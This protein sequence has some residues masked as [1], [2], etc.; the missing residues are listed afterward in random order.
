MRTHYLYRFLIL[1]VVSCLFEAQA[2][3]PAIAGRKESRA[4]FVLDQDTASLRQA[5]NNLDGKRSFA[6]ED[7]AE[8]FGAIQ[9][10]ELSSIATTESPDLQQPD[11]PDQP[12][13]FEEFKKTLQ[14]TTQYE[15]DD[16]TPA[17]LPAT[18]FTPVNYYVVEEDILLNE[19]ELL[20]FHQQ[21]QELTRLAK[22]GSSDRSAFP[23]SFTSADPTTSSHIQTPLRAATEQNKIVR[24][25]PGSTLRYSIAKWTFGG[26]TEKYN[27][28]K[29]NM[30]AAC[31]AWEE[32][33]NIKFEH[34]S[35]L[36][37]AARGTVFPV[38]ANGRRQ[39]LF[40]VV[41]QDI[42]D[43]I[44]RAF[45]PNDS[46]NRRIL[47]V[48]PEQ[49][50]E[51]RIDKV[52]VF[53]HELGHVLGFRHEHISPDAPAW[54]SSFCS[55]ESSTNSKPIIAY[56]RAS[57]MH[58]PC[59]AQLGSG[60]LPENMKLEISAL[61]KTGAQAVYGPPGGSPTGNLQFRDF[62]PLR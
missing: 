31:R 34:I 9:K 15:A 28:V 6:K 30:Q 53:R 25:V 32:A 5:L 26:D 11:S 62:D 59:T 41:Q 48:D 57:V 54:S 10:L 60:P 52:G 43:T 55:L 14:V 24:W 21:T 40:V 46:I 17:L 49:Y 1:A 58:Y 44:A 33:C 42:E 36:D 35:S 16:G 51:T 22:S 18:G 29:A 45:F 13:E 3:S 2:E 38:D 47:V 27:L 12:N 56:D 4:K 50:Y 61:D 19:L 8:L 20:I 23:T 39:V 7:V 37:T